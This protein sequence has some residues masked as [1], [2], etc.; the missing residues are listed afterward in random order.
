MMEEVD[1]EVE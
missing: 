1:D